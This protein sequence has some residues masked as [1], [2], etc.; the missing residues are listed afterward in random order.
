MNDTRTTFRDKLLASEPVS[1]EL[2]R[3]YEEELA[4]MFDQKLTKPR[5]WGMAAITVVMFVQ[6]AFFSYAVFRFSELPLLARLGFGLGM[7]FSLAF[8]ALLINMIRKGSY[9]LRRDANAMTGIVWIFLVFFVTLT[10]LLAGGME[11]RVA[12]VQMIVN[13][14]IFFIMGLAFLLKN[15]T[16]QA[17]LKTRE[18][19]LELEYRLASIDEKLGKQA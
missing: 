14:T 2:K 3:K 16:E 10:L 5:R 9:N 11:D 6:F 13:V 15:A 4:S 17:E 12:A 7:V 18:K 19:L 1:G 8:A